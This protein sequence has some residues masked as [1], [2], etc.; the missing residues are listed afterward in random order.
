MKFSYK[1]E[2]IRENL[3]EILL[4]VS[5]SYYKEG[6]EWYDKANKLAKE[7]SK[8]Y[9][10]SHYKV[11][12]IIA[13]LSPQ[14]SWSENIK[15]VD[16]FLRT[17]CKECKHTTIL[18]KKAIDIYNTKDKNSVNDILKGKKIMNFYNNILNPSDDKY[19][20]LDV[21]MIQILTQNYKLKT[22]TALQYEFLKDIFIKFAKEKHFN[23]SSMQSI[24]WLYFRVNKKR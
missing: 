8:K 5:L 12:G 20:T 19:A 13:A 17:K 1:E 14:K 6:L 2:F 16:L 3:E 15:L 11:C 23:S 7:F 4:G 22:L 21:H 24:L 10:V 18:H 9:G